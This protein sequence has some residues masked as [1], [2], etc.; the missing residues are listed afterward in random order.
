M[1]PTEL[2]R[3]PMTPPNDTLSWPEIVAFYAELA[4]ERGQALQPMLSLVGF[5]ASSR[6]ARS[7]FPR[8]SD[9]TL[10]IARV[11]NFEAG[12]G[13]LQIRFDEKAQTFWFTHLQ[14]P[15][16]LN[17]WARECSADEWR[18]V[19]ERLLHKRLQWFHEG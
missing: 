17:P 16:H 1:L 12:E 9:S 13:E 19:L 4:K 14:R 3:A 18:H 6:Y 11:S 2:E 8:V 15:D 7:L 5:L 10:R